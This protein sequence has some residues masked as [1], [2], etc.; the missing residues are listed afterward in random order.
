M[1]N[2]GLPPQTS[3]S[4][5]LPGKAGGTPV[6]I[7]LHQHRVR[8]RR[9]KRDVEVDLLPQDM[10]VTVGVADVEALQHG[11]GADDVAAEGRGADRQGLHLAAGRV[12]VECELVCE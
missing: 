9:V 3:N 1:D 4:Y 11:L 2:P 12:E 6:G 10:V 7:S 5:C 8:M